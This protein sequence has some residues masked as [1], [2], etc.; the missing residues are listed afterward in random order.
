VAHPDIAF[1]SSSFR[2]AV[3]F[4]NLLGMDS[5]MP[6]A[7]QSALDDMPSYPFADFTWVDGA[8]GSEFNGKSG[9]FVEAEYGHHPGML[10]KVDY[11]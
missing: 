4:A 7:W 11:K 10:P 9:F 8:T 5:D 3:R 2:N 6:A 1:A